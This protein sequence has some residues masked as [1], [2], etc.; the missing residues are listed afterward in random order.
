MMTQISEAGKTVFTDQAS[1]IQHFPLPEKKQQLTAFLGLVEYCRTWIPNFSVI[2]SFLSATTRKTS[3]D[4]GVL[5][6]LSK[7][8]SKNLKSPLLPPSTLRLSNYSLPFPR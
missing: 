7:D 4:P 2:A 6:P 8:V 5:G 3:P 1:I